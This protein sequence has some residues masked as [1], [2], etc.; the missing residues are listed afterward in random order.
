MCS[1]RDPLKLKFRHSKATVNHDTTACALP[2]LPYD[3]LRYNDSLINNSFADLWKQVGMKALLDRQ[4]LHEVS[5][6]TDDSYF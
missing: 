1:L 3:L 2:A 5:F 6:N 4:V